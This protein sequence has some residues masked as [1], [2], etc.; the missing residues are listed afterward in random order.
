MFQYDYILG[1]T[2]QEVNEYGKEGWEIIG[3]V[4]KPPLP[5]TFDIFIKKGFQ[6]KTYIENV[7]TG[8][9][10]WIDETINYGDAFVIF[11]FIAFSIVIIAKS[12]IKFFYQQL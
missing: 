7:D 6:E 11:I 2:I 4:V 10:F 1:K 5:Y 8:A 3:I 12:I 9:K